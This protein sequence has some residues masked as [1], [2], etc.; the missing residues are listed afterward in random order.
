MEASNYDMTNSLAQI[1]D[2]IQSC[3]FNTLECNLTS[4]FVQFVNPVMGAC[5]SFNTNGENN[6]LR[7]GPLYGLRLLLNAN[8]SE[9]LDSSDE[10]GVRIMVHE[11]T[12]VALPEVFGFNVQT[13]TG[14]A[15][16]LNYVCINF[17]RV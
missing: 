7:S 11:L 4:N 8:Y 3:T 16:G 15:L 9:Y 1:E 14:T 10:G 13:G 12:E 6:A 5:F 2:F 17:L